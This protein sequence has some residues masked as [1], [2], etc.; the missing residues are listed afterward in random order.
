MPGSVPANIFK[1]RQ[2]FAGISLLGA[3][4]DLDSPQAPFVNILNA[5][6]IAETYGDAAILA[7]GLVVDGL[8]AFNDNLWDACN[9]VVHHK[10]NFTKPGEEDKRDFV[11]RGVQFADRYFGGD[12][13]KMTHCLKHVF[14]WKKWLDIKRTH[15]AIDWSTVKELDEHFVDATTLAGAACAGGACEIKF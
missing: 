8:R 13:R 4:G 15:Q 10:G 11:R 5:K 2:W 14:L 6:E 9:G 3:S 12:I 7:S 1:N